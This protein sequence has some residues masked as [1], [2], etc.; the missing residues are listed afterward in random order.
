MS[1]PSHSAVSP[2]PAPTEGLDP[3]YLR[4]SRVYDHED[5][6]RTFVRALEGGE[7]EAAL[8]LE[9]IQCAGCALRNEQHLQQ[10]PGVVLAEVNFSTHRARVRWNPQRTRLSDILTAVKRIGYTAHPYDPDRQEALLERERRQ[11]LRRLGVAGA[12]GMQVMMIAVALYAGDWYGMQE[13]FRRVFLWISLALTVPVLM[14]SARPFFSA[15]MRD[16]RNRRI[17]M[18]VPVSL[19][20]GIAFAGSAFATFTGVGAVYFDSVVMF[21]FFLLLARYL[22]LM[23]RKH[24]AQL[25]EALVQPLPFMATR[26]AA[27]GELSVVAVT[28]LEA[29][30][31][32]LV[33]PGAQIPADG[34]VVEG[35]ANVDEALLTGESR[36]V[37][38]NVNDTVVGGSINLDSPLQILVEHTGPET[39]LSRILALVERARNERP[40]LARA[41]DRVAG[42]FVTI[43]L[44]LAGITALYWWQ[45]APER[46]LPITVA[47]LVVTCPCALSLATPTAIAA[48]TGALTRSALIVTRSNALE[49]LAKSTHMVFDKTGTLTHG[50]ARVVKTI[51]L[52]GMPS[53]ECARIAEAIEKSSEHPIARALV[54]NRSSHDVATDVVNTPGAGLQATVAGTRYAIGSPA[55]VESRT[56]HRLTGDML[57]EDPETGCS[58]V[59]LADSASLRCAF[60]VSDRIRPDARRVVRAL[61][62]KGVEVSLYSGDNRDVTVH[63]ASE[64]GIDDVAANLPPEDKLRRL[65]ALQARGAVVA[66]VG[67]GVNDTPV[68]SGADVSIAMGDGA[69]AARASADMIL[70]GNDLSSLAGGVTIARRTLTVIHQNLL[71]AVAYNMLA[72]PAAAA[73]FVPP[74]MAAV[75]MSASS[76][77]VVAN[78]LR[79]GRTRN[80]VRAAD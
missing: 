5:V 50:Q 10:L 38:K 45:I 28:E 16:L 69:Q 1:T 56:G 73:G 18:D 34:R 64:I 15:A 65:R 31:R 25:A 51:A 72:I 76:L 26:V 58:L 19:G 77:L 32:V 70:L 23:A 66:M 8:V 43:V 30:D 78:S 48:A 41:A 24:S 2:L 36:P 71:W 22:E 52:S 79:L 68:L 17:G 14:Y 62:D 4:E 80:D 3:D 75:G 37:L 47:M 21:V 33:R 13:G 61:Q 7:L 44:I 57:G 39:V 59:L 35:R 6:Q 74:W 67:D 49:T 53:D 11:Q 46:W 29:G 55:F 27:S 20:I 9:G 42:Y 54:A 60:Y 63:V 40:R 12:F